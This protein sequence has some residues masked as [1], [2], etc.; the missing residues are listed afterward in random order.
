MRWN[1]AT[2]LFGFDFHATG[3]AV[4]ERRDQGTHLPVHRPTCFI[5]AAE[6]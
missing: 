5:T 6:G 4:A 3:I 2:Y 1:L